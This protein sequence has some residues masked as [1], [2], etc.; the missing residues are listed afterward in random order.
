VKVDVTG[1]L[2]DP[3]INVR[4]TPRRFKGIPWTRKTGYLSKY[5]IDYMGNPS[6]SPWAIQSAVRDILEEVF[7]EVSEEL[8]ELRASEMMV[9][10]TLEDDL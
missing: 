7:R 5:V 2:S 3:K 1:R 10:V 9:N 6:L 8:G 4:V